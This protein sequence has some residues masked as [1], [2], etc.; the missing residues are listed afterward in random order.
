MHYNL[1][2]REEPVAETSEDVK[3]I[4]LRMDQDFMARAKAGDAPAL[5]EGFYA[6]DARVMPLNREVIHG[7]RAIVQLWRGV[8]AAGL[9]DLKLETSHIE[10]DGG[11]AYGIGEFHMTVEQGANRLEQ[12]GKYLVVYRRQADSSWR[13]VADM[14]HPN[15]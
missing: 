13:A 15:S 6:E 12:S 5:V 4:L 11:M 3:A 2:F 9:R 7:R 10:V 14:F 8:I 1:A